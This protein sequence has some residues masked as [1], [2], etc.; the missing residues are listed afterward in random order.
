MSRIVF[1]DLG[2]VVISLFIVEVLLQIFVQGLIYTTIHTR[3][4]MSVDCTSLVFMKELSERLELRDSKHGGK[5]CT[6]KQTDFFFQSKAEITLKPL[7]KLQIFESSTQ[8]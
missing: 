5:Y 3:T 4:N 2:K 8:C 1:A 6:E 7:Y